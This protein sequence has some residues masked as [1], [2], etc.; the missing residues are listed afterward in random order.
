[1]LTKIRYCLSMMLCISLMVQITAVRVEA[2][3]QEMTITIGK[4]NIWSLGQAHYLLANMRN[5]NRGLK[6]ASPGELNPNS[7]NGARLD[8]L[9]TLLGIEAQFSMPQALQNTVAQQQFQADFARKQSAIAR[10]DELSGEQL[11]VIREISDL[12]IELAK[13]GPQPPEDQRVAET[14]R[15]RQELTQGRAAKVV[16]RDAIAGQITTVGTQANAAATLNNLQ[17]AMPLGTPS[18]PSLPAEGIGDIKELI[19]KML[20]GGIPDADASQKLD[21]YVDMQYEVIAKQLTLLRDEVGPD[22]RL[23]FLELPSSLY[24]VP[25]RDDDQAVQIEWNVAEYMELCDDQDGMANAERFRQIKRELLEA[26]EWV[27]ALSG[28]I[29]SNRGNS[30]APPITDEYLARFY[31]LLNTYGYLDHVVDYVYAEPYNQLLKQKEDLGKQQ[32]SLQIQRDSLDAKI[33]NLKASETNRQDDDIAEVSQDREEVDRKL[34]EVRRQFKTVERQFNRLSNKLEADGLSDRIKTLNQSVKQKETE[35]KDQQKRGRQVASRNVTNDVEE[36]RDMLVAYPQLLSMGWTRTNPTFTPTPTPSPSPNSTSRP[37]RHHVQLD[38]NWR[39]QI[40]LRTARCPEGNPPPRSKVRVIDIVPRQS[41]LNVNDVHATQKGFALT[42]KFLAI[43]GFGAQVSYQRQRSVYEQFINQDVFAS[44]FGKGTETFGWTMGPLPG[45]KRL[46][47]GPRTTFAIVA[48][49]SDVW[50][51]NLQA[52]AVVYPRGKSPT[53]DADARF[54]KVLTTEPASFDLFVPNETTEGFWADRIDYTPVRKGERVTAVLSGRYFSPLTGV[55]VDG[56]PLKRVVAIAKHESDSTTLPLAA[57]S[58]GEYEYLNPNQIIISFK[59]SDANFVG[60]PLITLV[61]P[62]KT[63]AINFFRDMRINYRFIDSLQHH[64][65]I[66]P[67]F[68]DDFALSRLDVESRF[69]DTATTP[70]GAPVSV[71]L[72]GAGFRRRAEICLNGQCV[73]DPPLTNTGLYEL[74]FRKP[75]GRVWTITYRLGQKMASKDFDTEVDGMK[76]D[77]PTID[78]IENPSTGKAEGLTSGGYTVIIRGS[79]LQS[80]SAV[81]F[82]SAVVPASGIHQLKHSK[83]LLVQVPK[84]QE[85]GVQVLLKGTMPSTVAG[86]ASRTV[87]NILDFIVPGKAI[88]IYVRPTTNPAPPPTGR[89]KGPKAK[90]N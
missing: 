16:L 49:P 27:A 35:L 15:R 50:K 40:G 26:R 10:L 4:P 17:T 64:S 57:D 70:V 53:N 87:S 52:N 74:T 32:S 69:L 86:Q 85:G 90:P 22:E 30:Q 34:D 5:T 43:F 71:R 80:V 61:T 39:P 67:M 21:N 68:M 7:I 12:D 89:T 48:I 36:L 62:E 81:Y 20:N 66:E 8:V 37:D 47:P 11:K 88:F 44:G 38:L 29:E 59:A 46:A 76:A 24:T 23:V 25:K 2:Q 3:R 83:V 79:N 31:S 18:T 84:G 56:I 13:L 72:S 65:L 54:R 60:T 82:G 77:A 41:A 42:A 1:M 33:R 45:T 19:T 9:R 63:A 78:G 73:I 28:L 14:E 58:T 75:R 55:L 51:I 6:V